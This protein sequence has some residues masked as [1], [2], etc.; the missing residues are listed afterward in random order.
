MLF[1][2][3]R[4]SVSGFIWITEITSL[5][6]KGIILKRE[7]FPRRERLTSLGYFMDISFY[8]LK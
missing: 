5:L 4:M 6:E 2:N 3:R 8:I 1:K 7:N